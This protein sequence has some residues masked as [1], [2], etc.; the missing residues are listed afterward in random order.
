MAHLHTRHDNQPER[1][2]AGSRCGKGARTGKSDG[3]EASKAARARTGQPRPKGSSKSENASKPAS[4]ISRRKETAQHSTAAHEG[5]YEVGY[6]KPPKQHQFKK[7][8]SG[9]PTGKSNKPSKPKLASDHLGELIAN[10]MLET[11]EVMI[12][13]KRMKLTNLELIAQKIVMMG[14]KAETPAQ[15][16]ALMTVFENLAVM[17]FIKDKVETEKPED[18]PSGPWT[19]ELEARFNM[20][21]KE[22]WEL[23]NSST[24]END[25]IAGD[26]ERDED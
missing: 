22:I 3:G 8:R 5:T 23:E 26:D 12:E 16:K 20:L 18:E 15:V 19:P 21:E 10:T 6:K 17:Q 14:L 25:N 13:G 24:A 1:E 2:G 9:N 11:R 7:G 4:E